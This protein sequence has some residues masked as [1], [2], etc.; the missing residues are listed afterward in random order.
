MDNELIVSLDKQKGRCVIAN[1][2]F[3]KGELIDQNHVILVDYEKIKDSEIA[4]F[5]FDWNGG[6]AILLGA[7][8][9]I[10]HSSRNPNSRIERDLENGLARC[11]AIRDI[12]KGEE[13][14]AAYCCPLWFEEA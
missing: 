10:N 12:K 9:L 2:D 8:S 7:I 6:D 11:Y 14:T 1:R 13:I 4:P 5:C 3:R